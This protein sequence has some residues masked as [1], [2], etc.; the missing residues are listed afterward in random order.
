MCLVQHISLAAAADQLLHAAQP[1]RPLLPTPP[2]ARQV[3]CEGTKN[4]VAAAQQQARLWHAFHNPQLLLVLCCAIASWWRRRSSRRGCGMPAAAP[5]G[6]HCCRRHL[7]RCCSVSPLSCRASRNCAG[8]HNLSSV[9]ALHLFFFLPQGVKKFVLVTSIG[10]DDP[11]FPL[12]A[13]WVR[14]LGCWC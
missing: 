8:L 14:C 9:A 7:I 3:D 12:N 6:P 2:R 1:A 5:G 4:L 10:C 11:L 13:F